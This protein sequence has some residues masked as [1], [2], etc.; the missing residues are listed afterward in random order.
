VGPNSDESLVTSALNLQNNAW[1]GGLA[2][3]PPILDGSRQRFEV[4]I[5][6]LF[7]V[8]RRFVLQY[9]TF[10]REYVV[11][12]VQGVFVVCLIKQ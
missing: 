9:E 3:T 5:C 2:D 7:K 1:P 6:T 8:T 12:C 10:L 4:W 11:C